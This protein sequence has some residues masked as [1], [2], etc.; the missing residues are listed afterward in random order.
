MSLKKE[1][2]TENR[3]GQNSAS[4]TPRDYHVWYRYLQWFS[5]VKCNPAFAICTANTGCDPMASK[6]LPNLH[7]MNNWVLKPEV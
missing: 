5:H 1:K 3:N 7:D 4:I 2:W 6:R